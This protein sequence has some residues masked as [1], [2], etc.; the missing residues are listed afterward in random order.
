M[1]AVHPSIRPYHARS[2]RVPGLFSVSLLTALRPRAATVAS[3]MRL[4]RPRIALP[5]REWSLGAG[6]G[7][8]LA[9]AALSACAV[10]LRRHARMQLGGSATAIGADGLTQP[11]L[12]GGPERPGAMALFCHEIRTPLH[13]IV[14]ILELL[15]RKAG[16]STEIAHYLESAHRCAR[17]LMALAGGM[18]DMAKLDAG[19]LEIRPEPVQLQ[20]DLRHLVDEF[21]PLAE[22]RGLG[23][24][25]HVGPLAAHCHRTDPQ[26]LR[27]I[28]GNLLGNAIKF[29]EQGIVR[30]TLDS[31][32]KTADGEVLRIAV[33]DQG[34]GIAAADLEGL[35]RPF[36][37]GDGAAGIPGTG[38]GLAISRELA[39][40]LGGELRL[41]S[42]MGAGTEAI[43]TLT[44]RCEAPALDCRPGMRPGMRPA[45]AASHPTPALFHRARALVVD[46]HPASRLLLAGQLRLLGIDATCAADGDEALAR[47]ATAGMP[48]DLVLTDCNM[49]GMT[50]YEMAR[51]LRQRERELGSG[52]CVLLGCSADASQEHRS[53]AL[54]AGMDDCLSK[55]IDLQ[56][57]ANH[58]ERWLPLAATALPVGT[59]WRRPGQH[60]EPGQAAPLAVPPHEPPDADAIRRALLAG[61]ADDLAGLRR[62]VAGGHL[63]VAGQLA[64]RI[65]G[66]ACMAA[67]A[68]VAG[69][70]AVVES[71]C[72]SGDIAA[73]RAALRALE[74]ALQRWLVRL[75]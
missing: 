30:V 26:R 70:A 55:P 42:R 56:A 34:P 67:E 49:P 21:R 61:S 43:L 73:T 23:I 45:P 54:L 60:R 57:L 65:R 10:A 75:A 72:A 31:L 11:T 18:L 25:L 50:G 62:A 66:A 44:L 9:A 6:Q 51:A 22:E 19:L 63:A 46:D 69:L 3:P 2:F 12:P 74:P 40:R 47:H 17:S 14:G 27:Q 24:G 1:P 68:Q 28:L 16:V 35:F 13:A 8:L 37:R 58:L 52:R 64:H 15:S 32:G 71:A 48:F 33:R 36:F 5:L 29:S 20:R 39:R 41:A 59:R 53:R 4:P 38:L 7:S